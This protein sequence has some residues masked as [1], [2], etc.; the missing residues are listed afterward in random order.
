MSVGQLTSGGQATELSQPPGRVRARPLQRFTPARCAWRRSWLPRRAARWEI[1]PSR[2]AAP[3]RGPQ[4]HPPRPSRLGLT[5]AAGEGAGGGGGSYW[6][7]RPLRGVSAGP[8]APPP[9]LTMGA[10]RARGRGR[11]S[12][13]PGR[14]KLATPRCAHLCLPRHRAPSPSL[15]RRWHRPRGSGHTAPSP[16]KTSP[17]RVPSDTRRRDLSLRESARSASPQPL[18]AAVKPTFPL[19]RF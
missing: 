14:T 2:G 5:R 9:D 11:R 10:G 13:R 17:R 18:R 4:R 3:E 16:G 1:G 8:D 19:S 15:P 12:A 6:P 7:R